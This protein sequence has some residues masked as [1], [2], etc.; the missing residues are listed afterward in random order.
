MMELAN[1]ER[2]PVNP[3]R[4]PPLLGKDEEEDTGES[5]MDVLNIFRNSSLTQFSFIALE[6]EEEGEER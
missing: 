6:E 5:R 4:A 3:A 1:L 2:R